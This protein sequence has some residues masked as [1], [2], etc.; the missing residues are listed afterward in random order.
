MVVVGVVV[1]VS[2][3]V[4]GFES[5]TGAPH[6]VKGPSF[7]VSGPMYQCPSPPVKR[8]APWMIPG[9]SYPV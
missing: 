5:D 2:V 1:V 6:S 8:W 4:A 3:L 9:P 7:V